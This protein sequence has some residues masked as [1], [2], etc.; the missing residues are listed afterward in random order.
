M[1]DVVLQF[2]LILTYLAIGLI[3]VTFPI[4]AICVSYL[5]QEKWESKKDRKRRI[6]RLKNEITKLTNELSGEPEDSNRFREMQRRIADSRSEL[7]NLKTRPSFLTAKG[8]VARPIIFLL[9]SL[10]FAGVGMYFH[11]DG[12]EQNAI[13]GGWL[14]AAFSF[15]AIFNLYKTI[16]AIEYAALRPA[17]TI[18]F[19]IGFLP[20]RTDTKQLE[21]GKE[22]TLKIYGMTREDNIDDCFMVVR[23]PPEIEV[24]TIPAEPFVSVTEHP[25]HTT[26]GAS[27][28]F[29]PKNVGFGVLPSVIPRKIGKYTL[30]LLICGKGIYEFRK[31]LTLD[32]V[33]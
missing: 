1:S 27:I 30:N 10:L 28:G 29:R 2:L 19:W 17:R 9:C 32:V 12:S 15:V 16:S 23:I 3:S 14:S 24:V 22:S 21:V 8:A 20:G 4:Y 26:I 33:K 18:D 5:R 6:D 11:Y 7:V 31:E 25:T 13:I